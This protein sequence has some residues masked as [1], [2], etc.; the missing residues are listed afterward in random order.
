MSD[1]QKILALLIGLGMFTSAVMP[2]HKTAEVA[3]AVGGVF[4]GSLKVAM[5]GK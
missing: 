4:T 3:K 2:E 5:T 1:L